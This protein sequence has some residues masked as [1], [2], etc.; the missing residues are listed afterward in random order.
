MRSLLWSLQGKPTGGLMSQ[1]IVEYEAIRKQLVDQ[2]L[3]RGGCKR[4]FVHARWRPL[5]RA[6]TKRRDRNGEQE[7]KGRHKE[8]VWQEK[9]RIIGEEESA[10]EG[11]GK[12]DGGKED[13]EKTH[14][15]QEIQV[16]GKEKV[17]QKTG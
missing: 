17:C 13:S 11:S 15:C 10:K 4:L 5:R 12:K 2:K 6:E 3:D 8:A 9:S 16:G 14:G 1:C 7:E